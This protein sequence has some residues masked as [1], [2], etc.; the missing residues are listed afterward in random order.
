MEKNA[1][2]NKKRQKEEREG[3]RRKEISAAIA[4][5]RGLDFTAKTIVLSGT[6]DSFLTKSNAF[7]ATRK[8][9]PSPFPAR[10]I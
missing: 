10:P 5:Q 4:A 3:E 2:K 9:P 7:R 8:T 6:I 1:S